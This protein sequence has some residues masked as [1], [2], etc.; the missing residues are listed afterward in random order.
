MFALEHVFRASKMASFWVS[1][2]N[3]RVVST[4]TPSKTNSSHLKHWVALG[5]ENE[6]PFGKAMLNGSDLVGVKLLDTF[7]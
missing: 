7:I 5:L 3:F 6:S 4:P 2:L 1:M